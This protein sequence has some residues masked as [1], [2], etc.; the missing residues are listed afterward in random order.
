[1]PEQGL[2]LLP[3]HAAVGPPDVVECVVVRRH[4]TMLRYRRGGVK[5]SVVRQRSNTGLNLTRR[6][7][8]V[9]QEREGR[10]G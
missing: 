1:M 7:G 8:G 9:G 4:G 3:V 2:D 5:M 6:A 10:A